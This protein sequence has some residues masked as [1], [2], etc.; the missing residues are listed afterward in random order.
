GGGPGH[1]GELPLQAA[2]VHELQAEVGPA[3][4]LADLVD[5]DDV[6]VLEPGGGLGLGLEAGQV[7]RAAEV[8]G[9]DH[10]QGHQPAQAALAGRVAP[11]HTAAAQLLKQLVVPDPAAGAGLAAGCGNGRAA[12]AEDGCGGGGGWIDGAT[13]SDGLVDL[14]ELF[15]VGAPLGEAGE[16]VG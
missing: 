13:A 3:L 7:V 16:P 8:A 11:P 9:Q 10:L 4:V 15:Q 12:R 1:A 14:E 6:G 2:A 5:L